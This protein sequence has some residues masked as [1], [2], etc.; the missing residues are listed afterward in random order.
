MAFFP[1]DATGKPNLTGGASTTHE[2]VVTNA[3]FFIIN[4]TDAAIT[5]SVTGVQTGTTTATNP[6]I[7]TG[8]T[9]SGNEP[10]HNVHSNGEVTLQPHSVIVYASGS[11]TTASDV[12]MNNV[13]TTHGTSIA[14]G[15]YVYITV[16]S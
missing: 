8:R 10:S 15:E 12:T 11:S 13:R 16:D 3:H 5:F 9:A 2:G 14:E 4:S 6:H 7:D 1:L